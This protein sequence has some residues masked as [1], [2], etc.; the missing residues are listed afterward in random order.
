MRGLVDALSAGDTRGALDWIATAERSQ[1]S[2]AIDEAHTLGLKV[3]FTVKQFSVA[4]VSPDASDPNRTLVRYGGQV[5]FCVTGTT[6]GRAVDNCSAVQSLSGKGN[7]DTFV[8]VRQG[9]RWY[10]SISGAA[11]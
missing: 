6:A 2:S 10:V 5:T 4:S 7:A 8:C 11:T 1:F 9:G 3:V